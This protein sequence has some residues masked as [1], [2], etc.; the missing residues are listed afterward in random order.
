M[1]A[2]KICIQ[3]I[4]IS[5]LTQYEA[6]LGFRFKFIR[7][8][9]CSV[10]DLWLG[11]AALQWQLTRI[12]FFSSSSSSADEQEDWNRWRWGENSLRENIAI[13][14]SSL[15]VINFMLKTFHSDET[16]IFWSP[17]VILLHYVAPTMPGEHQRLLSVCRCGL[18]IMEEC[19]PLCRSSAFK[20]Q[21]LSQR[22]QDRCFVALA[23]K[24]I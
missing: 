19:T 17:K 12:T 14:A 9:T 4:Y 10:I 6:G 18:R 16:T 3:N 23:W 7:T 24:L 11:N 13:L 2:W 8:L 22:N 15:I 21:V 20:C 1:Y 5:S